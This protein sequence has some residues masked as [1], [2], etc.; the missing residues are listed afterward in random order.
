VAAEQL[1]A[2]TK[3]LRKRQLRQNRRC[4][5]MCHKPPEG[6]K[7]NKERSGRSYSPQDIV[8]CHGSVPGIY[9]PGQKQHVLQ[10]T[11]HISQPQL[12]AE[13]ILEEERT[14]NAQLQ[15]KIAQLQVG[16]AC[17]L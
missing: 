13:R 7:I 9:G 11:R 15:I 10:E 16:H 14:K 17:L 1:D 8:Y 5:R 12:H 3:A 6:T 4:I 2:L